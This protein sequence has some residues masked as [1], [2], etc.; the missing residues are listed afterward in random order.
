VGDK[1]KPVDQTK[2][3]DQT[4]PVEL[5]GGKTFVRNALGKVAWGAAAVVGTAVLTTILVYVGNRVSDGAIIRLLGGITVSQLANAE[6]P[7]Q[8]HTNCGDRHESYMGDAKKIFCFLSDISIRVGNSIDVDK[9]L[10]GWDVCKIEEGTGINKGRLMLI[11][12]TDGICPS[13]PPRSPEITCKAR[14]IRF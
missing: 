6:P 3:T 11:A 10:N 2:P 7:F 8:S 5:T 14:C 13:Q 9:N 1:A 12:Q 4:K